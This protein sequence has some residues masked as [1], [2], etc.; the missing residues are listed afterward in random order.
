MLLLAHAALGFIAYFQNKYGVTPEVAAAA[1]AGEASADDLPGLE[2]A[3]DF[4]HH[5]ERSDDNR[6]LGGGIV[7]AVLVRDGRHV[8]LFEYALSALI[9]KL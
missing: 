7:G 4:W 9:S 6:G 2:I 3:G 5:P 8:W 1:W